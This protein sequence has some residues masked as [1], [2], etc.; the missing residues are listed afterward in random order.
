MS[1]AGIAG[2]QQAALFGQL[3][4]EPGLPENTHGTDCFIRHHTGPTPVS[5]KNRLVT[6]VACATGGRTDNALEGS[7]IVA[8]AVVQWL[9]DR[10]GL[11]RT[12]DAAAGLVGERQGVRSAYGLHF[13][14]SA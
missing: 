7:V 5:S 9:R 8:G 2:D 6:T 12:A 1:I 4:T 13:R 3:C 10:L 11:I 14:H